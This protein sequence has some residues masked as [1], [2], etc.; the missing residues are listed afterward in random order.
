MSS[1]DRRDRAT[2]EGLDGMMSRVIQESSLVGVSDAQLPHA[3]LDDRL[4][5]RSQAT[6]MVVAAANGQQLL[7]T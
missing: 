5:E 6:G 2:A 4:F 1:A 3:R 7:A